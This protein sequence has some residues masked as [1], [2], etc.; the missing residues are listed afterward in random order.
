ML[1]VAAA[2]FLPLAHA[3]DQTAAQPPDEP[4]ESVE[5]VP[6]APQ[7]PEPVAQVSTE[8]APPDQPAEPAELEALGEGV[9]VIFRGTELIRIYR[10]LGLLS[11][12]ERAQ[13]SE[14]RLTRLIEDPTV[15]PEELSLVHGETTSEIMLRDRVVGVIH[16]VD[17]EVLN[18]SREVYGS[19]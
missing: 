18:L 16:G 15:R 12:E 19:D 2:V 7:P 6:T 4:V 3:Q 13:V 11:P 9:P 1:L 10:P 8:P 5:Q 17:A 14:E